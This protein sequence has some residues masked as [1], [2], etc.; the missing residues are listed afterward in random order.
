VCFL[1]PRPVSHD[2]KDVWGRSVEDFWVVGNAGYIAH[3]GP[4]GLTVLPSETELSGVWGSAAE[5]VWAVGAEILHFNGRKWSPVLRAERFLLDV[6]GTGADNVWAVGQAGV[7]YAKSGATWGRRRT[8]M[9]SGRTATWCGRWA[10]A[11]PSA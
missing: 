10:P 6:Y 3:G 1:N 9:A 5:D 7:V 2:F 8:S 11:P 4:G